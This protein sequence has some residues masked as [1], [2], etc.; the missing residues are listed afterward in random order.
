M[1]V[2][3]VPSSRSGTPKGTTKGPRVQCA[4]GSRHGIDCEGSCRG[5]QRVGRSSV[6][7]SPTERTGA[8]SL[9]LQLSAVVDAR[10]RF[11]E[12]LS[13]G[14]R[15]DGS[16]TIRIGRDAELMHGCPLRRRLSVVGGSTRRRAVLAKFGIRTLESSPG[17]PSGVTRPWMYEQNWPVDPRCGSLM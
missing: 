1:G 2:L 15:V 5:C 17:S 6:A 14:R 3:A 4:P 13:S 12:P 16:T 11:P 8:R 7:A 10:R 9:Q